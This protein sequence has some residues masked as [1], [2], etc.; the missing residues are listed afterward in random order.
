MRY[1]VCK[2]SWISLGNVW[3]NYSRGVSRV[4]EQP[5]QAS[6]HQLRSNL[7]GK[8][9]S[10]IL[11]CFLH[12]KW[13]QINTLIVCW[14]TVLEIYSWSTLKFQRVFLNENSANFNFENCFDN[15]G[16]KILSGTSAKLV[17]GPT[18]Q[19]CCVAG[20]CDGKKH[21][22]ALRYFL[23]GI[24][25][26]PLWYIFFLKRF[27]TNLINI[28]W[29]KDY[30]ITLGKYIRVVNILSVSRATSEIFVPH[31]LNGSPFNCLQIL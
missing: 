25:Y 31:L 21:V 27:Q 12:P 10:C 5:Q 3:L 14:Y 13:W 23:K 18:I 17:C 19:V 26:E 20:M 1:L 7:L 16:Y 24:L 29:Q 11:I 8:I 28:G 2:A 9:N 15:N 6:F 30:R 4:L 22:S